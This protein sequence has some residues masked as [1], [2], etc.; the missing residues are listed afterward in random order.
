MSEIKRIGE[1]GTPM[2]MAA[3]VMYNG[4][5]MKD[6]GTS[7]RLTI[8]TAKGDAALAVVARS[9]LDPYDG[10]A[11]TLTAG[12]E[13]P[14]FPLGCGKIVEVAS[15][16]S[17]VYTNSAKV[18]LDNS[19]DGQVSASAT[20]STPIGRYIGAGVTTSAGGELIPVWLCIEPDAATE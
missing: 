20:T 1:G 8:I 4:Y 7:G 2:P 9:S 6:S 14:V 18:Y 12:D 17:A 3:E 10:T 13:W 19:V 15:I 5:V 16:T 11:E